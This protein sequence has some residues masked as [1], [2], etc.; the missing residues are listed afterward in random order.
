[1]KK[2][3]TLFIILFFGLYLHAQVPQK[4]SYQ[5]V[6]RNNLNNLVSNANVGIKVS[7][8]Q[9][10]ASGTSVYTETHVTSTRSLCMCSAD[11]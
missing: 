1:M 9:G 3:Y 5:A 4:M 10:S 7:V 8:L 2:T 11:A 6:I